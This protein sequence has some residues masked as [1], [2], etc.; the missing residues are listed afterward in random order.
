MDASL[1]KA[2]AFP[3]ALLYEPSRGNLNSVGI[4]VVVGHDGPCGE[5]TLILGSAYDGVHEEAASIALDVGVGELV[6]TDGDDDIAQLGCCGSGDT[7]AL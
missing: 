4:D 7:Q 5:E 2:L 1:A 6:A 3:T